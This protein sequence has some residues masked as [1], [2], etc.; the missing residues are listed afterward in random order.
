MD[1]IVVVDVP[2]EVAVDRLVRQRQFSEADALAR[3]ANQITRDE[4]RLLAD[5]LID[6]S[7]DRAHLVAEVERA[8]GLIVECDTLSI[9]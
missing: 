3:I 5:I 1:L 7:R 9:D 8:W 6:N 2:I 4:R